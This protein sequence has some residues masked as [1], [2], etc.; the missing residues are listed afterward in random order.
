MSIFQQ[1]VKKKKSTEKWSE[2][3]YIKHNFVILKNAYNLNTLT[4]YQV[5]N[6]ELHKLLRH[7]NLTLDMKTGVIVFSSLSYP[8]H[9]MTLNLKCSH[10]LKIFNNSFVKADSKIF[11]SLSD[12]SGP[13]VHNIRMFLFSNSVHNFSFTIDGVKGWRYNKEMHIKVCRTEFDLLLLQK[14]TVPSFCNA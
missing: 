3:I 4:K 7:Y 5:L 6:T 12:K 9:T 13:T 10:K 1:S 11:I 2:Y 8:T 14:L